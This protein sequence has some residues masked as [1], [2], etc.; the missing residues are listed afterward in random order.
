L[1]GIFFLDG[2]VETNLAHLLLHVVPELDGP[3]HQH[4]AAPGSIIIFVV[5]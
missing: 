5:A 4:G 2:A 1:D 3:V